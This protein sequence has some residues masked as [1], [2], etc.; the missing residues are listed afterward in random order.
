MIHCVV[1]CGD[2]ARLALIAIPRAI[3]RGV[4]AGQQRGGEA[5]ASDMSPAKTLLQKFELLLM[6]QPPRVNVAATYR[7]AI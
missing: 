3:A 6:L 2:G 5:V 7:Q 1:L 4:G